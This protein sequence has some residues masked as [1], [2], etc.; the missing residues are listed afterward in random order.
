MIGHASP[1]EWRIDLHLVTEGM[2]DRLT[3]EV[4][5]GVAGSREDVPDGKRVQ[6]PACMDVRLAEVGVALG[7][8]FLCQ[9][10]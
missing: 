9:R 8:L 5:V 6:R 1:V 4:L 10:G 7:I 2:L 3:L